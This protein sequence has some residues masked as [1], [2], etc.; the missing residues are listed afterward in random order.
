MS[1]ILDHLLSGNGSS[2][3]IGKQKMCLP[4]IYADSS[5]RQLLLKQILCVLPHIFCVLHFH[6][7]LFLLYLSVKEALKRKKELSCNS[8]FSSVNFSQSIFNGLLPAIDPSEKC[9]FSRLRHSK[10]HDAPVKGNG[11]I[12]YPA[13]N[14]ALRSFSFHEH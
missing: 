4:H 12:S 10:Q 9:Y 6:N 3:Q 11:K 14:S 8:S 2:V 5:L 13:P 1:L 7:L